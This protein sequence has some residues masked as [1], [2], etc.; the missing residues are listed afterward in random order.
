MTIRRA[1]AAALALGT[2]LLALILAPLALNPYLPFEDLPNHIARRAILALPGSALE[3]YFTY[4]ESL[5]T[6]AA[7][8]LA[9]HLFAPLGMSAV[10]FSHWAMGFAMAGFVLSVAVLHRVLH[11]HWSVWPLT[12]AL[13]VYNAN[14]LWGFENFVVT[15]PFAIFGLALWVATRGQGVLLRL[16]LTAAVVA[17]LFVG[18]VFVLLAYAILVFGYEGG[19]SRQAGHVD[20]R[21]VNWAGLA[22]VLAACAAYVA[23]SASEPAP[24]Y[25][26]ATRFGTWADRIDLF[27]APLGS[28]WA[29]PSLAPLLAQGP[30]L[31]A[32]LVVLIILARRAGASVRVAA[33]MKAP[34]LLLGVVTVLMPAQLSGVYFTHLRY[35]F[36]LLGIIIAAT[37]PKVNTPWLRNVAVLALVGLVASRAYVLDRAAGAYSA[38]V[39][40]V[41]ALGAHLPAG[42]RVLPVTGADAPRM[43]TLH[44]HTA[45]YLVPFAQAF[46]PTLFLGGSHALGIAPQ[47]QALTAPQPAAVPAQLL[48][49]AAEAWSDELNEAWAFL[50]DWPQNFTHVLV[51]GTLPDG[52]RAT[53]PLTPIATTRDMALYAVAPRA[54]P[55]EPRA[56]PNLMGE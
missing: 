38:Q 20:L 19:R 52:E 32:G 5:G 37:D 4:R 53:L 13:L 51:I 47:W 8:D 40:Q 26:T 14:T 23:L 41:A 45:A 6:N 3:N 46:V 50:Q 55:P 15:A 44:F 42:A 18:H 10:A 49:F 35:P 11:G 36:L 31:L 2:L 28:S 1:E 29:G 22:V 25:G 12:A 17:V 33:G 30:F 27:Y 43:A 56:T 54:P 16:A 7:V 34:I 24:G 9:W 48:G 21:G 39:G